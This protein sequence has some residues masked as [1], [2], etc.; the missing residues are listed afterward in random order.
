ML[1]S[2]LIAM[3]SSMLTKSQPRL[4]LLEAACSEIFDPTSDHFHHPHSECSEEQPLNLHKDGDNVYINGAVAD[5]PQEDTMDDNCGRDS[6]LLCGVSGCKRNGKPFRSLN[7]LTRHNNITH[8]QMIC[9]LCGISGHRP[10][11]RKCN[12]RIAEATVSEKNNS[13]KKPRYSC[14]YCDIDFISKYNKNRHEANNC[15]IAKL[16]KQNGGGISDLK[17]EPLI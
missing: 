10:L 13:T 4:D 6:V 8:K 11:S 14:A 1:I 15:H 3:D 17:Q 2:K 12:K 5:R 7:A 16:L 9:A